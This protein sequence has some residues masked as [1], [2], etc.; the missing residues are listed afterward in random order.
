MEC[1]CFLYYAAAHDVGVGLA[2]VFPCAEHMRP[3]PIDLDSRREMR[4]NPVIRSAADLQFK[5]VLAVVG[6]FGKDMQPA[7]NRVRPRF[8][9]CSAP[10][11][12][13]T[14]AITGIFYVFVQID[15]WREGGVQVSFHSE[16]LVREIGHGGVHADSGCVVERGAE[17]HQGNAQGQLPTIIVAAAKNEFWSRSRGQRLGRRLRGQSLGGGLRGSGHCFGAR[18]DA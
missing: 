14:R 15:R 2:A 3:Q 1:V 5:S 12:L 18:R 7:H 8:P 16:P 4:Q 11:H 17:S 10:G 6:R 13:R 9:L